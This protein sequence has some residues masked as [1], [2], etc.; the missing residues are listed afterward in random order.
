MCTGPAAGA[1]SASWAA[2][3]LCRPR[4][5]LAAVSRPV[6]PPTPASLQGLIP[7]PPRGL[8]QRNPACPPRPIPSLRRLAPSPGAA[9]LLPAP[10]RGLGHAGEETKGLGGGVLFGAR[11]RGAPPA[12]APSRPGNASFPTEPS[13]EP[14]GPSDFSPCLGT[15]GPGEPSLQTSMRDAGSS[16]PPAP[17]DLGAASIWPLGTL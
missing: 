8:A 1:Q 16:W 5:G 6:V 2:S 14:P 3:P 13:A 12:P 17:G 7:A 11:E 9:A 10:G 4:Q 15:Q